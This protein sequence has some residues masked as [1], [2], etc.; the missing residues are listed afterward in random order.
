MVRVIVSHVNQYLQNLVSG[1]VYHRQK[2]EAYRHIPTLAK[3][4][5]R[6]LF[7]NTAGAAGAEG[8]TQSHASYGDLQLTTLGMKHGRRGEYNP[9]DDTYQNLLLTSLAPAVHPRLSSDPFICSSSDKY[10]HPLS[11][12]ADSVEPFGL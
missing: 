1:R 6:Y 10:R 7:L 9:V 12:F 2:S 11:T 8:R 4:V 3:K 5:R